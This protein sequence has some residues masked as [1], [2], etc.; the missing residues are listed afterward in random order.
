MGVNRIAM[1]IIVV[2]CAGL[3]VMV[4]RSGQ[5]LERT[6]GILLFLVGIVFLG[7]LGLRNARCKQQSTETMLR[8]AGPSA[9]PKWRFGLSVLLIVLGIVVIVTLPKKISGYIFVGVGLAGL[10][11]FN[12][13]R[14]GQFDQRR[15]KP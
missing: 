7:W 9:A 1:T 2:P 4:L 8:T 14:G 12:V 11:G 6:S 15:P 3:A 10:L 5:P 13:F